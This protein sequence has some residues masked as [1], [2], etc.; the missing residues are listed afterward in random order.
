MVDSVECRFQVGVE[1]PQALGGLA[2]RRRVDGHNRVMTA[3]AGTE[4]VDLRF[5][6][7]LPLG[8]QCIQCQSLEAS[9]S[10]H[11]NS[12]RAL[13]S[14]RLGDIHP[15]DG[16]G[17]PRG[18]AMLDPVGQLGLFLGQQDDFSVNTRRLA[19]GVDLRDPPHTRECVGAGAE[20]QLLQVPDLG[21]V[22]CLRRRKDA[23]PQTPYVVLDLPPVDRRPVGDLVLRS[24]RHGDGGRCGLS[25]PGRVCRH[26]V[27]LA[28]RFRCLRSSLLHKLTRP[29]SAPFQVGVSAPI[30]PVMREP[31]TEVSACGSRFP[32]AFRPPAFACWVFLRPLESWAFLA[33]GLPGQ[34]VH[35]LDSIGVV[36]FRMREM[37]PGRVPSAPRGRRC[38]PDRS[39]ISGRRLPLFNGQSLSPAETTHRR[40]C[41]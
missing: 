26:G 25:R 9:V 5:Q 37:L 28:L 36:T 38:T 21:Q 16:L 3:T 19:A 31:P 1:H 29:T 12:E 34:K 22:S 8:L 4:A 11:G 23:L 20:Y 33:V 40:E 7:R 2:A 41:S 10:D 35:C 14:I 32:A 39:G 18:R 17:F 15:L 24:V 30:R 13:F 6:P 27:Q